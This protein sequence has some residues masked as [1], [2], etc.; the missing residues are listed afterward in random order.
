MEN[1]LLL[2]T[3]IPTSPLVII[4]TLSS[5]NQEVGYPVGFTHLGTY[6]KNHWVFGVNPQKKTAKN[7][8][9]LNPISDC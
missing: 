5:P 1:K 6:P 2:T 9:K 8:T 7:C 4:I 3:T